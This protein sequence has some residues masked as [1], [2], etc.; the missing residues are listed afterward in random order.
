[1]DN[2][3]LIATCPE[4]SFH[5]LSEPVLSR[6]SIIFVG[7]HEIEEKEKIIKNYSK[8]VGDINDQYLYEIIDLFKKKQ[9]TDIK[10]I[11]NFIDIFHEMNVCNK[12]DNKN[13]DYIKYYIQL[14]KDDSKINS[15]LL[16][17]NSPI[18]LKEG[19]LCSKVSN[20]SVYINLSLFKIII[21]TF[22]LSK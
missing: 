17:N 1:M 6:F 7:E 16:D 12:L 8:E 20:L 14:E 13:F 19:S 9:L 15:L 5:T 18:Y 21:Q 22:H 10:K 11:K 2:I 3:G 4:S